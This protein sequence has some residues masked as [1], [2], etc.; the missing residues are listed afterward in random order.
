MKKLKIEIKRLD[1]VGILIE[2]RK[3]EIEFDETRGD[4]VK[5]N[6][7]HEGMKREHLFLQI[8]EHTYRVGDDGELT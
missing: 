7:V 5:E 3:M 1:P 2:K 4:V 8:G 6:E